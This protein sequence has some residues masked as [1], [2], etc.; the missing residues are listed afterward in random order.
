MSVE[1]DEPPPVIECDGCEG[2]SPKMGNPTCAGCM[3]RMQKA[4][5]GASALIQ[6]GC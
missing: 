4:G 5:S 2:E 6:V 1:K 3:A